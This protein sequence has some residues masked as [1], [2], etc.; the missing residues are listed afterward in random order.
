V[1]TAKTA[2][3]SGAEIDLFT[4]PRCNN[5]QHNILFISVPLATLVPNLILT[6]FGDSAQPSSVPVQ[7]VTL[8]DLQINAT[9]QNRAIFYFRKY[10]T[11]LT[12][13]LHSNWSHYAITAL[14][15]IWLAGTY[16]VPSNT[17]KTFSLGR[18]AFE[19]RVRKLMA[20][21]LKT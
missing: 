6:E 16:K 4:T 8:S 2:S 11:L 18:V 5:T 7:E 21:R 1:L 9:K 15:Q 13:R 12:E 19:L 3:I 17:C 10:V 20:V 14:T